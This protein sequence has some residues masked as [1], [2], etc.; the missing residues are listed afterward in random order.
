MYSDILFKVEQV[1]KSRKIHPK[2]NSYTCVLL[3]EGPDKIADKIREEAEETIFAGGISGS[4]IDL[5]NE[6]ADLLYHLMVFLVINDLSIVDV[7]N[8]LLDRYNNGSK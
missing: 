7:N 8:V 3:S 2:E 1:I 4:K 5:A 6:A